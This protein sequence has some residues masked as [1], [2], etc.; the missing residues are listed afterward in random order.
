[1]DNMLHG[2]EFDAL[3]PIIKPEK[4]TVDGVLAFAFHNAGE[5][6]VIINRFWTI[7]AG[8]NWMLSVPLPNVAIFSLLS[9]EFAAGAGTKRLEV[10]TLRLT[11]KKYSNL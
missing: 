1:M 9:V 7:K 6:D 2:A 10:G 3:P 8:A 5:V 11:G 4:V